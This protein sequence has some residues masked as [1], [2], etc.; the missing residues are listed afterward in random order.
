MAESA[1][2]NTERTDYLDENTLKA[3]ET[4]EK[5][6]TDN[7]LALL[8]YVYEKM[9]DS[10]TPADPTAAEPEL[11]PVLMDSF[12]NLSHT[13]Q[14]NAMRDIVNCADTEYSRAYG[15]LKENN[16]LLVWFDWAERMGDTVVGM[17]SDYN[18]P[19]SVNTSLGQI[20]ALEFEQQITLLR[21]IARGMGHT[22]VKPIPTQTETG[23]TSS[24]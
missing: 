1:N 7:K 9:G 15:A 4:Y 6:G 16:Q 8:Y 23:K 12:Y 22:D 17:P 2:Q 21:E 14:L 5:L 19:E 20:E 18:V 10:V 24:L 3:V 11:S 13:D